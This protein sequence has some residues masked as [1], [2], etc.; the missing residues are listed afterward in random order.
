MTN[1]RYQPPWTLDTKCITLHVIGI[2]PIR[3]QMEAPTITHDTIRKVDQCLN[4]CQF[5]VLSMCTKLYRWLSV[6]HL[7]SV[8]DLLFCLFQCL[9]SVDK[10]LQIDVSM[11]AKGY[12]I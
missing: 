7:L 1:A 11:F 2:H 4:H 6:P 12:L 9:Y 8:D 5:L 3:I 10:F